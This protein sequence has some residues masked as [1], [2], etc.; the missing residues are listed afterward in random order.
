M[1]STLC[2]L[3][4]ASSTL[5]HSARAQ[6]VALSRFQAGEL[7]TDG[8]AL[9]R[10]DDF[11]HRR[12]GAQITL[13]YGLNP[14]V[15]ETHPGDAES[16]STAIVEHQAVAQLGLSFGIA[17]R[18]VV[19]AGLPVNVLQTGSSVAGIAQADGGG[20]GDALLG[21]RLRLFG[22]RDDVFAIALQATGTAPLAA[23]LND[24]QSYSGDSDMTVTPELLLELRG[25]PVRVTGNVGARFRETATVPTLRVRNEL[26]YALG[27]TIAAVRRPTH[28]VLDLHAEV[29]GVTALADFGAQTLSPLEG[30]VGLK[31]SPSCTF[32]LGL[33][34]GAG[35]LRGY[36]SPDVRGVLT[37]GYA[38]A[39][40]EPGPPP[41]PPPPPAPVDPDRDDDGI[42]NVVDECPDAAEDVDQHED[43]DGC[44]ELDNDRDR[45]PDARD[46]APNEPEDI[47]D[48]EDW[49]GVPEPDND[50]DGVLDGTDHCP[51][52]A[53][54]RD[55]IA[56][57]DG[58]P[59]DDA[60]GDTVLDA[61][62]HCP[63]TPGVRTQGHPEC[64]GC[65]AL[66][67]MTSEGTITIL[68][69]VEFATGSDR[70]LAP[71]E[72]V[73]LAVQ[74]ILAT[75]PQIRRLRVEGHTDDRGN[76][77]RNLTLSQSR[78]ESVVRWLTAH[79]IAVDRLEAQGLG[80]TR[81]LVPNRSSR[82]RQVNRR[83]EFHITDPAPPG[84]PAASAPAAV[85]APAAAPAAAAPAATPTAR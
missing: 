74:Q 82:N 34:G 76:D 66:A 67:C 62:D 7:A 32:H 6:S 2:L 15:Y 19:F 36:G 48:F 85:S 29:Y 72:P 73:L 78:A 80:E 20:V 14:L 71:S 79:E 70:I 28:S 26:V 43:A 59:E 77:A 21:L 38:D 11:G 51:I 33:A 9:S 25:G 5:A 24:S 41:P 16:E 27:L 30:I 54:D 50:R 49:D 46:G 18:L 60:D 4:A 56:D 57:D 1:L 44:P 75:N 53:E 45:V 35:L 13:D 84:A 64:E 42:A 61:A 63:L 68:E 23:A 55:G 47:D 8:F 17:N 83:V 31:L 3:T 12:F 69:R 37:L 65:P 10:P 52:V 39:C 40:A 58:C 22:E 81:P